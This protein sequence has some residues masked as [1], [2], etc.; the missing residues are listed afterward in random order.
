[1]GGPMGVRGASGWREVEQP[2]GA[3][4]EGFPWSLRGGEDGGWVWQRRWRRA[5]APAAAAADVSV[6]A[7]GGGRLR[8]LPWPPQRP[9]PWC[10]ALRRRRH[11]AERTSRPRR[12]GGRMPQRRWPAGVTWCILHAPPPPPCVQRQYLV[13]RETPRR[14]RSRSGCRC[15][16]ESPLRWHWQRRSWPHSPASW[17]PRPSR[18]CVSDLG[19][20]EGGGKAAAAAAAAASVAQRLAAKAA[21][22]RGD[23]SAAAERLAAAMGRRSGR[24]GGKKRERRQLWVWRAA[25]TAAA[26]LWVADWAASLEGLASAYGEASP[27]FGERDP[28]AL[29]FA[30]PSIRHSLLLLPTSCSCQREGQWSATAPLITPPAVL[31]GHARPPDRPPAHLPACPPACPSLAAALML[32]LLLPPLP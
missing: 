3:V 7:G 21:E 5:T 13:P 19:G 6:V 2:A 11:R 23:E 9:R 30:P 24:L 8:H 14:A 1:M 26:E 22:G 16:G 17:P 4:G 32:R 12:V 25:A 27:R 20:G 29:D 28:F 31:L 10:G 15:G 18:L